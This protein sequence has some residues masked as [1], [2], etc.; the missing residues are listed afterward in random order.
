MKKIF[1][2]IIF[3]LAVAACE[4]EGSLTPTDGI[5]NYFEIPA[6]A[7]DAESV[8]RREF[9][10]ETGCYLLFND[11]LRKE[12]LGR[13]EDGYPY[14]SFETV[15]LGYGITSSSKDRFT[16]RYLA[17][18]AEKNEAV[19]FVK[20]RVLPVMDEELYPYSLLLVDSLFRVRYMLEE[21][22]SESTGWFPST[23]TVLA[24]YSGARCLALALAGLSDMTDAEKS[25]FIKDMFEG[26]IGS[27][28][29]TRTTELSEFYASG[30]QYYGEEGELD[31]DY[32]LEDLREV[33][34]LAGRIR[35][36]YVYFPTA[37]EDLES[38][39]EVLFEN[40]EDF[41]AEN[42]DYPLVIEKY[43]IIKEFVRNLGYR[44]DMLGN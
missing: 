19:D 41:L 33:G 21:G 14:Y 39:V 29:S 13:D 12:L 7:T 43:N 16:F 42:E 31:W 18:M 9:F 22:A 10:L 3:L 17:D 35:Y 34:F 6:D 40:E 20:N 23:K 26:M 2:M 27:A 36:G 1:Y 8:L 25:E 37:S 11:T 24:Y 28:L 5:E 44:L 4:K 15:D 30:E 38:Y 32:Y